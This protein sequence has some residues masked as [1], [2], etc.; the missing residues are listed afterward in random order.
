MIRF[1]ITGLLR[2]K[3]RS[4][5]PIL[6]VAIG[7]TQTV[8]MHAYVTGF[9][10]DS[11]ELNA[12]FTS[13]HM[14]VMTK[15]YAENMSQ[16]PNDMALIGADALLEK[17]KTDYPEADWVPRIQFG[18]L[19][20]VPD[21]SGE[22]RSQ[23]PAMGL[24][25]D[26]LN[27]SSGE[28]DRL[29]LEKS[30]VQGAMIQAPGDALLSEHFARKLGVHPGDHF[31]LIGSTMNGSMSFYNFK[32]V[33]TVSFGNEVLDRVLL[34]STSMMPGWRLIWKMLQEKFSGF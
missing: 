23:G 33:G 21:A 30:M 22:T 4:R 31:T 26:L 5:M 14:K 29:N 12:R 11:I 32:V 17:L 13:G 9:M 10:G 1:L 34:W 24:A 2:D 27:P 18:G 3:S 19:I 15:G 25:L 6:V 16:A 20:D 28:A 7:V 8:F